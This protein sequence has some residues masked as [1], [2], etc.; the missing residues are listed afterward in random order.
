[1]LSRSA[2][3]RAATEVQRSRMPSMRTS[4]TCPARRWISD[5][6]REL[7]AIRSWSKVIALLRVARQ[8]GNR[9]EGVVQRPCRAECPR[10][11]RFSGPAAAGGAG[12]FPFCRWD[13]D[14]FQ[15][16]VPVGDGAVDVVEERLLEGAGHRTARSRSDGHL[17]DRPDRG[18]LDGGPAE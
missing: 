15:P 5:A 14:V 2:A 4:G 7:A 10:K 6:P 11:L 1:M 18:D 13:I 3:L 17:V 16:A 8:M 12:R 9:P